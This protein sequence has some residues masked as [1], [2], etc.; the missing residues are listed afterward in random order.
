VSAEAELSVVPRSLVWA[1]DIDVLAMDRVVERRDR[2]LVVRSPGNPGHYWGNLLLFD[3]PPEIGDAARW[4]QSFEAEFGNIPGVRHRTFAWDRTDGELGF[5]EEEFGSRGYDLEQHVGLIGTPGGIR[6]HP[7]EN[8]EVAVRTLDPATGADRELWEQVLRLQ[9]ASRD[10]R[11]EENMYRDYLRDRL[12]DL[13][14]LF[15]AGKGAWFVALDPAGHEVQA[16]CGI[17]VH[18]DRGRFQAVDTAYAHR[19]RGICSRLVVEAAHLT[20]KRHGTARFVIAAD[21]NYHALGLYESLGF[22]RAEG[23]SG[24]YRQPGATGRE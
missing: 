9:L 21:P 16:S 22:E 20:A 2:Y 6:S 17:V 4:E 23:V 7:R 10:E 14:E 8:R 5:A 18:G 19:R 3:R 1:T 24:V 13:R 11:F 12:A 15:R